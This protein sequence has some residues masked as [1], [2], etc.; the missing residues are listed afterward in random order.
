[1]HWRPLAFLTIGLFASAVALA[2]ITPA[3]GYTPPS[4][5]PAIKVGGT[6]F[7]DYTY[8]D[9]PEIIDA[10]G[11]RVHSNAFNVGRAYVNVTGQLHHLLSFRITP[12]IVRETGSGS[13]LSGSYTVRLKY[14]YAQF[15]MDDWFPRGS[16]VR[17]GMQQTPY[18]DFH[19]TVYRYRFQGAIFVD[20]EGFLS[21]SDLGLTSRFAFPSNYGD[22]HL[23]VYNGEGYTRSEANDQ[24]AFQVRLTVRPAPAVNVLRGLRLTGFWDADHY[25]RDAKRQRAIAFLTFE[26]PYVNVGAEYLTAKD[27]T[28]L[29]ARE[30]EAEGWSA[31]VTPR[32]PIGIEGL[33]RYDELKPDTDQDEERKKKRTIAGVA[34]WFTFFK[35]GVTAA[36]LANYE[37]VKYD[38]FSP[39]RPTEKRYA[40]HML[41]NF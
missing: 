37:N 12:D 3:E 22:V 35:P 38:R 40:L 25:V 6:I 34:Y 20:R 11:D 21:S 41:L 15:N 7:L 28:T 4:D 32:T 27:Q 16:W 24:K 5:D 8:Q 29:A 17:L 30:I 26:H 23:G 31:W 39:S 18:V 36:L 14:G 10:N 1:M 33:F 2:Q 19:E 13:S 9:A